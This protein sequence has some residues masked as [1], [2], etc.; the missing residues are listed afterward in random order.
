MVCLADVEGYA[1]REL[2]GIMGTPIGTVIS[3]LHRGRRQLRQLLRDYA[4]T[5]CPVT[6]AGGAKDRAVA[7][8][9]AR[10]RR[11]DW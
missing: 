4:A 1:Y 5:R 6:M 9:G 10:G 8:A 7:R 11:Q 3:R 2:A